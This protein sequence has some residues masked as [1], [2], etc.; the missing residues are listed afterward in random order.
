MT[1]RI[2]QARV[3]HPHVRYWHKADID[4]DTKGA[5][6]ALRYSIIKRSPRWRTNRNE[7]ELR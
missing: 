4:F 2:A 1:N 3:P 6:A 5:P 7:M